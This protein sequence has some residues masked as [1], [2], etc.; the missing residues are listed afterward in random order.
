VPCDY[1]VE[2]S[3]EMPPVPVVAI[4]VLPSDSSRRHV[5][6]AATDL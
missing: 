5:I 3:E 4:D 6:D 1:L 2:E